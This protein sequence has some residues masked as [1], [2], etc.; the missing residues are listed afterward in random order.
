MKK[1]TPNFI[2][3]N[4]NTN[5]SGEELPYITISNSKSNSSKNQSSKNSSNN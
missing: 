2:S 3:L 4:F 5:N 1:E